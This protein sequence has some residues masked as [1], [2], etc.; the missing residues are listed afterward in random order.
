[1]LKVA[2]AD[3]FAGQ[4]KK[5]LAKRGKFANPGHRGFPPCTSTTLALMSNLHGSKAPFPASNQILVVRVNET[6]QVTP[7]IPTTSCVGGQ[8]QHSMSCPAQSPKKSTYSLSYNVILTL[9]DRLNV[10]VKS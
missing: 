1:M 2:A 7:V 10:P 5:T 9:L 8:N 6:K 3:E 4:T